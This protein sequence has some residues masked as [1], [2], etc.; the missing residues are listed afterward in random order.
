MWVRAAA[1]EKVARDGGN[2]GEAKGGWNG[3]GPRATG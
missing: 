1:I 2:G 3:H